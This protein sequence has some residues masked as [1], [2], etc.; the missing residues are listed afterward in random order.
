MCVWRRKGKMERVLDSCG[1]IR[2]EC[3]VSLLEEVD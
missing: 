3:F 2:K 1:E